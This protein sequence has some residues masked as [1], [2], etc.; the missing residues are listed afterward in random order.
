MVCLVV[1]LVLFKAVDG[2]SEWLRMSL[3]HG[4]RR[5]ESRST[6]PTLVLCRMRYEATLVV[7]KQ[8]VGV[9]TLV[10]SLVCKQTVGVATLVL[11]NHLVLLTS[12]SAQYAV[13]LLALLISFYFTGFP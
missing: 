3:G 11:C 9:A 5:G 2:G 8:T 6:P 12:L 7:C 4:L 10:L 1:C 13:P